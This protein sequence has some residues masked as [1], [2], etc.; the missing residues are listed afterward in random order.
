MLKDAA[1]SQGFQV[2]VAENN[3]MTK[4]PVRVLI[5]KRTAANFNSLLSEI[6]ARLKPA[7]AVRRVYTADGTR[8][9][10][11][12]DLEHNGHYVAAGRIRF[13]QLPY[14]SEEHGAGQGP[15]PLSPTRR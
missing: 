6:T 1:R 10:S 9:E 5:N 8:I 2:Y 14:F 15:A 3:D 4:A 11:V 13:R 12:A 7:A